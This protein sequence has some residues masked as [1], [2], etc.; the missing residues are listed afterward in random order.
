[1]NL[2]YGAA[3][4]LYALDVTGAGRHPGHERW[5]IDHARDPRDG[6]RIGFFDGLHGVAYVLAHLGHDEAST[7]VLDIC[8]GEHWEA[9]SDDLFGG[10]AGMGLNFAELGDALGEPALH[11][12]ALRATQIVADRLG[13]VDDVADVSGGDHPHAG[14]MRGSAGRAL[15]F[16]RMYDRLGE[17]NLLDLAAVALRQD[18]RR[19]V[20]RQE[21]GQ[22]HVN[23]GWRTMPYLDAGSTG[24][25]LVLAR[26]LRHRS[27]HDLADAASA[28]R[29][30][31]CSP[32]YA[33]PGLFSGRA[34]MVLYLADSRRPGESAEGTLAAQVRRLDWHAI[35]DEGHLAFPGNQLLRLSMDLA[36]GSA[37]VLLALGAALD[38]RPVHLP[39][40]GP[41]LSVRSESTRQLRGG[42]HHDTSGPAGHGDQCE[43]RREPQR[44][45]RDRLPR[46]EQPQ[47]VHV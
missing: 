39:F 16:L 24:I 22:L 5:L 34:G 4:V 23:E 43:Q 17:P 41:P 45:E 12:A 21:D 19:C 27:D 30:A 33:Q 14:L 25:G 28:I 29:G 1:L 44:A 2:A 35:D 8:L 20:R 47:P 3:G 31:A 6:T 38:D 13:E 37:G 26:Y 18:L 7:R 15:L 46:Q 32:F 10:L 11:D 42:E 36:T 40:L 9:S